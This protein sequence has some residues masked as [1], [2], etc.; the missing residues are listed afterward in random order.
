MFNLR[1]ES[2]SPRTSIVKAS[3][4]FI[5]R[6]RNPKLSPSN[7]VHAGQPG[8]CWNPAVSY[9]GSSERTLSDDT[10]RAQDCEGHQAV[11]QKHSAHYGKQRKTHIRVSRKAERRENSPSRTQ[12]QITQLQAN[13]VFLGP[14]PDQTCWSPHS[15]PRTSLR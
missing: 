12:I 14:A 10:G 3:C 13:V 7:A 15:F 1:V 5:H 6:R 4:Y 9:T 8:V 2:N 11:A